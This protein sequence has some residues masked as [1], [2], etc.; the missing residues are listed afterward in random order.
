MASATARAVWL[1]EPDTPQ[2]RADA[3]QA[4]A[5][6]IPRVQAPPNQGFFIA[7]DATGLSLRRAGDEN[8]A[9]LRCALVDPVELA[10]R[11]AG[12]RRSPLARA[13]GLHR[14][15]PMRVLDTT[16]GLARDAATLAWLGCDVTA[17]ER[18][19]AL[20]A[21]LADATQAIIDAAADTSDWQAHWQSPVHADARAWLAHHGAEIPCEAIYID[22]MF[23]S[24]RR[25]A[26]PQKALAW[27]AALAGHDTDASALLAS[28]R[29][30]ASRRV[31]VKQHGR[32]EPMAPPDLQ[33]HG[34]AIRFDI[35]LTPGV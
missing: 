16:A 15:P 26:A 14:H 32:A 18:Q 24:P 35:Y 21:L 27:L 12:G 3:R 5:L 2:A 7:R 4:E 28:A 22:P 1:V 9:G 20:Y 25:K 23:T 31:V 33:I 19:P 11:R 34:R 29:Q 10:N 8:R 30:H 6:G 17:V 13:F